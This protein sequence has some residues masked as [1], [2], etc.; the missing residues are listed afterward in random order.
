VDQR[1]D[2]LFANYVRDA[3]RYCALVFDGQGI[4]AAIVDKP[5][6]PVS[7]YVMAGIY[8]YDGLAR[9]WQ[10]RGPSWTMCH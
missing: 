2:G 6:C 8:F 3:E 9:R 7:L 1:Q 5:F 4:G 10:L